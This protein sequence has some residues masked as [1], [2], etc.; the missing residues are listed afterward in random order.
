[1]QVD[2]MGWAGLWAGTVLGV[3]AGVMLRKLE[4]PTGHAL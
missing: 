1:M 4:D 3:A 2:L